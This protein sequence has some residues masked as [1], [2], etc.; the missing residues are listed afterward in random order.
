MPHL[1]PPQNWVFSLWLKKPDNEVVGCFAILGPK[2]GKA[3]FPEPL[4]KAVVVPKSVGL[5]E[6]HAPPFASL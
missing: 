6:A 3:D 4:K 5:S 2:I 1:S